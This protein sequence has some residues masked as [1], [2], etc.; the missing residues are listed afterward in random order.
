MT[1][2]V[3]R[4]I[5]VRGLVQGVGYRAFV[6]REAQ[7]LGIHGWVRNRSDGSVEAVFVGSPEAVT[8]AVERCRSGPR[9]ARVSAIDQRAGSEV[10]LSEILRSP[11]FVVLPTI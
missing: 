4:H 6:E 8:E 1:A 10:E 3:I 9:L 2:K 7:D 5:V 11:S